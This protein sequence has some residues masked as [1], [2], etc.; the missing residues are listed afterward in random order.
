[1]PVRRRAEHNLLRP[2]QGWELQSLL[3]CVRLA[4]STP[5]PHGCRL[6]C[7]ALPTRICFADS[8]YAVFAG[9]PPYRCPMPLFFG[10]RRHLPALPSPAPSS[11]ELSSATLHSPAPPSPA[12]LAG[13][14]V[15]TTL[16]AHRHHPRRHHPSLAPLRGWARSPRSGLERSCRRCNSRLSGGCASVLRAESAFVVAIIALLMLLLCRYYPGPTG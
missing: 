13:T 15:D 5:T 4:A 11:L 1:M 12:P 3:R 16:T 8:L 14:F 10:P 7:G 6:S 2:R 9:S